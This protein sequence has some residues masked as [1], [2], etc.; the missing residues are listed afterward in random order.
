MPVAFRDYYESLG[1]R[2]ATR[3]PRRSAGHI[4]RWRA[5]TTPTST[6]RPGADDRFKEISEAYEVSARSG[7]ARALRPARAPTGA[8]ARTS[9]GDP[10]LRA[11]SRASAGSAARR[12]PLRL[13]RETISATS[14]PGMFGR[15]TRAQ[16]SNGSADGFSR[17]GAI[18]RPYSS[19]RWRRSRP[20]ASGACPWRTGATSRSTFRV[21]CAT[22]SASASPA[23]AS[24][25]SAA[26]QREISSCAFASLR[27]RTSASRGEISTP[28]CP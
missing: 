2:R 11:G 15:R 9:R 17:R 24:R 26:A 10:G 20:A 7:Q 27:T 14:S 23:R 18:K 25:A 6:R 12:R 4:A 16:R 8:P 22:A 3:A 19:S 21:A 1:R 5:S 13:R 28:T